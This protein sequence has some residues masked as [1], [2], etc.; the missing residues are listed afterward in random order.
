MDNYGQVI[1]LSQMSRL[2][3]WCKN[4]FL[5][6]FIRT[7]KMKKKTLHNLSLTKSNKQIVKNVRCI[8]TEVKRSVKRHYTFEWIEEVWSW[9]A[10]G[11]SN[12]SE[13]AKEMKTLLEHIQLSEHAPTAG[14][15]VWMFVHVLAH[16]V[17][18]L[19]MCPI[20]GPVWT[21]CALH[22]AVMG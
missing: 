1:K 8:D 6:L 12:R 20:S 18:Q 22:K 2:S 3:K 11:Q 10:T 16:W 9:K 4:S 5:E 13:A 17:H 7:F 15:Y 19:L 14:G 21:G